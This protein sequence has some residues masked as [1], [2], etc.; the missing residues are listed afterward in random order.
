MTAP[1]Q[2]EQGGDRLSVDELLNGAE[3]GKR[4]SEW[5]RLPMPTLFGLRMRGRTAL[6]ADNGGFT[7]A[8]PDA[9]GGKAAEQLAACSA[10]GATALSHGQPGS[11]SLVVLYDQFNPVGQ[12]YT[13]A[14]GQVT[15]TGSAPIT[16]DGL[17]QVVL[18]TGVVGGNTVNVQSNAADVALS[19][20]VGSDT[21]DIGAPLNDGSNTATLAQIL[22]PVRVAAYDNSAPTVIVDNSADTT[23]HDVTTG[24][25]GSR[26]YL[27][28]L[29]PGRLYFDVAPAGRV[30]V[31]PGSG[32][33]TGL[34][35]FFALLGQ[36]A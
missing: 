19:L 14:V 16:Y 23:A 27:A 13:F 28:G 4:G 1:V 35:A 31:K 5:L 17:N 18:Y 30:Q 33:V 10:Q 26:V 11:N 3:A 36:G 22:G 32:A 6:F 20:A 9:G 15:R 24:Q 8:R 21:V 29:A 25:E 34:D 12:T 7:R 2:A